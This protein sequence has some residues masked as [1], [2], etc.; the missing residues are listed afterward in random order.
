MLMRVTFGRVAWVV[1]A[2]V[3]AAAAGGVGYMW[4]RSQ[5]FGTMIELLQMEAAGNLT[6]RVEALSMLRMGDV[7]GAITRL[8][9]EVDT[10]TVNVALN[11]GADRNAL[12][13]VKTYLSVAPPS[14]ARAQRLS[15]ALDGVPT[16]TLDEC[17]TALR[18]LLASARERT[19]KEN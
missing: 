10:L 2:L 5:Q 1:L 9:S 12:A 7:P 3:M 17:Q 18:A 14:P 11:R 13:Y 19:P 16:L 15:P 4:G 8:E 6:Q